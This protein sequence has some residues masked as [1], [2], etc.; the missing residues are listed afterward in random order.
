MAMCLLW[1]T[2][3]H[4]LAQSEKD[5]V[6]VEVRRITITANGRAAHVTNGSGCSL[7]IYNLTGVKIAT[8]SIDTDD[9]RINLPLSKGCYLLKVGDVVR[10]VFIQ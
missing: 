10:K 5:G 4:V 8:V 6:E 3:Q 2:P 9:K 1:G 7:E